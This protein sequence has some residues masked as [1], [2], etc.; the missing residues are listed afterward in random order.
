MLFHD[1]LFPTFHTTHYFNL[2]LKY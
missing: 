1:N 2:D